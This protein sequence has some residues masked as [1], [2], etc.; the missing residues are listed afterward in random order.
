MRMTTVEVHEAEAHIEILIDTVL[1]GGEVVLTHLG[2]P[3]ASVHLR[4]RSPEAPQE[5]LRSTVVDVLDETLNQLREHF[6][7][8]AWLLN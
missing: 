8:P 4:H 6:A 1:Y 3:V 5:L 7:P 2:E